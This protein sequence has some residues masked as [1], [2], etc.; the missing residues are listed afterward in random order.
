MYIATV[1]NRSSPPAILLRE[2]YREGNKVRTR[3]LANLSSLTAV[4]VEGMR[5]ALKGDKLVSPED[6]FEKVRDET[7]GSVHAVTETMRRIGFSSLIDSRPS[8]ERD[9]VVAMVIARI[10]DPESKL[11]TVRWWHTTTLAKDLAIEGA[12]E[13]D[14]YAA[15][16]WLFS[17]Q[18]AIE[19]KLAKRHLREGAHALY[20]LS[21]SYFEGT[22]CPLAKLGHNRDGKRGKLQVNYG[23]VTDRRGCPVAVSVFAGNTADCTTVV[24]EVERIRQ[25]FG[26]REIVAVGDRG[27]ISRKQITAFG[28]M[29][30]VEWVTALRTESIKKLVTSGAL[31]LGL[32]D[33]R[34]LLAVEHPDFPGERLIACKNVEL[35]RLRAHKRE[36]LLVA[37]QVEL[38]KIRARVKNGRLSEKAK[39]GIAVGRVVNTYKVAKH[40]EVEITDTSFDYR[41]RQRAIVEEA[42]LDGV[43]V[44]R[45]SLPQTSADDAETVRA[46]KDLANVERA[47]RTMKTMSLK[48]RPIHH[49]LEI[50]VRAHIF[51]CMLAFY[52]EW[53]MREALRPILFSDEEQDAK[54]SRDPVAPAKRSETA[55]RKVH[56]R[57]LDDDTVVHSFATLLDELATITR[58]TMRRKDA[59]DNEP[60]FTLLTSLSPLH[61]KAFNL[62]AQIQL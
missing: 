28:A 24:S 55:L 49:R 39:I 35:A 43:Y 54:Q 21:S 46:Y 14:A 22:T 59:S 12:D 8:P 29:E 52:V 18:S 33:K 3:T 47:F 51:L 27:M 44:V 62:L 15:M 37:T 16:D 41:R 50:R 40:F 58:S 4:Q 61:Q 31:Q 36:S 32:F 45:T 10:L 11:G 30:G 56:T 34:N 57:K 13:E 48:V 53:H 60:T 23:L 26:L 2:S 7:H 20:D 6:V 9:L 25:E 17:R 5:R 19:A 38:D 42:S 1:P